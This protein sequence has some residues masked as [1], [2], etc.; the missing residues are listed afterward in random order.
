VYLN[1]AC[2][3][4]KGSN[5]SRSVNFSTYSEEEIDKISQMR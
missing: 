3:S 2:K 5:I 1:A 4:D